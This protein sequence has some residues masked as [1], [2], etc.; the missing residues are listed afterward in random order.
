MRRFWHVRSART[1]ALLIAAL[2]VLGISATFL[3][4][5]LIRLAS[6]TWPSWAAGLLNSVKDAAWA[7]TAV[8]GGAIGVAILGLF[9]LIAALIPGKRR[10]ALLNWDSTDT[11]EEWVIENRGLAHLARHEAQRTD[12]VDSASPVL[13][14]KKMQISVSTPVHEAS[15]ISKSVQKNVQ[16]AL[17]SIPLVQGISV[18]TKTNTRGGQ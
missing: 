13:R 3:V 10:T 5:S 4:V 7:D 2:V 11:L 14:G 6:G 15:V 1:A 8:L 12:G 18:S 16:D 17:V 9:L